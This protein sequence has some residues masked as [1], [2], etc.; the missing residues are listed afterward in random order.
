MNTDIVMIPDSYYPSLDDHGNYI[1]NIMPFN[2]KKKGINCP[3]GARKEKVYSTQATFSAHCKTTSHQK[4][5]ANINL[6]KANYYVENLKLNELVQNQRLI[7]S[8]LENDL[9]NRSITIDYLTQQL[10]KKQGTNNVN[11]LEFD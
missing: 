2:F 9:N 5:L 8:K 10:N 6:N 7:I 4:W 1:D 3:C 11:L